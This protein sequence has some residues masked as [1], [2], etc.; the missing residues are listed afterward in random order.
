MQVSNNKKET[1]LSVSADFVVSIFAHGSINICAS[2]II[3][4][5]HFYSYFL[6]LFFVKFAYHK[7]KCISHSGT[8]KENLPAECHREVLHRLLQPQ[9]N[10]LIAGMH[11]QTGSDEAHH[12]AHQAH[13]HG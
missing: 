5:I 12:R 7:P 13:D 1:T 4:L 10:D 11:K 9:R 6:F 2:Q 8:C 3:L